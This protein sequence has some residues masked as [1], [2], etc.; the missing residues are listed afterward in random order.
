MLNLM[1]LKELM[2]KVDLQESMA[3]IARD[4][5]RPSSWVRRAIGRYEFNQQDQEDIIQESLEQALR[6][7]H[8]FK[9]ESTLQSWFLGVTINL[10]RHHVRKQVRHSLRIVVDYQENE[11]LWENFTDDGRGDPD[12][13]LQDREFLAAFE[14]LLQKLPKNLFD[15][16]DKVCLKELSYQ[17]VANEL[18]I[19]IG[20]VRSRMNSARALLKN[21]T[22]YLCQ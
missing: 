11:N 4:A 20:T 9:G 5:F 1:L 2:I 6:S 17:D 22:R 21:S 18:H 7:L 13:R 12:A 16:F 8:T 3:I 15:V 14:L 10:A 19:P